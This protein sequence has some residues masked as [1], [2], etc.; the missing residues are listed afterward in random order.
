MDVI[1]KVNGFPNLFHGWGGED[2]ELAE[3]LAHANVT[4]TR[5]RNGTYQDLE[6]MSLHEKLGFL[7]KHRDVLKCNDKWEVA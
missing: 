4:I 1:Q 6:N 7:R 2:D 3:R 5:C